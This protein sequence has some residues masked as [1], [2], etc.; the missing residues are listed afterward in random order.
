MSSEPDKDK[1]LNTLWDKLEKLK[2]L[3]SHLPAPGTA[4]S[5]QTSQQLKG[6]IEKKLGFFPPFFAPAMEFP[7]LLEALWRHQLTSYIDNPLPE[8]FKELRDPASDESLDLAFVITPE[9][10]TLVLMGVGGLTL[11]RRKRR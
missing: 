6:E 9:P 11:L 2:R 4:T 10:A 3:E 7:A 5:S 8:L 1:E